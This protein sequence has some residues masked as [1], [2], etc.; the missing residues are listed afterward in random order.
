MDLSVVADPSRSRTLST[1][2]GGVPPARLARSAVP[3]APHPIIPI[4]A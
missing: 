3:I 2:I 4:L 1:A